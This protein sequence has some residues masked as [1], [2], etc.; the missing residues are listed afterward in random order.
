MWERRVVQGTE[1]VGK[2]EVEWVTEVS[3]VME[4]EGAVGVLWKGDELVRTEVQ[5]HAFLL[6]VCRSTIRHQSEKPLPKEASN[7]T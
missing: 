3:L 2:M 5:H 1:V 4:V 7:I 6:Y